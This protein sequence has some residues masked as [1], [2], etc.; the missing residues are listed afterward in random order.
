LNGIGVTRK[1]ALESLKSNLDLAWKHCREKRA[2]P[3]CAAVIMEKESEPLT[4][5]CFFCDEICN[6]AKLDTGS[7][8][9]WACGKHLLAV[10]KELR[11]KVTVSFPNEDTEELKSEE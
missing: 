2:K 5:K 7:R 3:P 10:H 1:T 9:L 6:V 4:H 11:P 8:V